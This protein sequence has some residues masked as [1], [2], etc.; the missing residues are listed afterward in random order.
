MFGPPWGAPA[1]GA[2]TA[3]P[4]T[5]QEKVFN[6]WQEIKGMS[7]ADPVFCLE[8]AVRDAH[9]K[10][11]V[12]RLTNSGLE[13]LEYASAGHAVAERLTEFGI[14]DEVSREYCPPSSRLDT[15]AS[16]LGE[17]TILARWRYTWDDTEFLIYKAKCRVDGCLTSLFLIL[18]P[19]PS[20]PA[21]M[22]ELV[23]EGHHRK[24]DAL[25]LAVGDYSRELHD[26]VHVFD[27][28]RWT[29]SK[30]LWRSVQSASWDDVILD[31]VMKSSIIAD[32]EGFFGSRAMYARLKVPWKR[33]V[34]L[35][36]VPGNG[37]TM[38]IK[39]L[40]NSLARRTEMP[41]QAL[42][43]KSLDSRRGAKSSIKQIFDMARLVAP[44]LLIFEDLDSLVTDE[45]KAYF[46][47]EVDGLEANDG[48]LMIG[49]TNHI[50]RLDPAITKRPSR[51]DRKYHYGLPAYAQR[52]E[53]ARYWR[54]NFEGSEDVDFPEEACDIIA[55]I[56][57]GYSFAYMKELFISSLMDLARGGT[58]EDTEDTEEAAAAKTAEKPHAVPAAEQGVSVGEGGGVLK[59]VVTTTNK[60][61]PEITVPEFLRD[62]KFLRIV[63]KQAKLLLSE[64]DNASAQ[65][66]QKVVVGESRGKRL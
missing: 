28:M 60:R 33:G 34:I 66:V 50:D 62:N 17:E 24:T 26:E 53:Y 1:W 5:S 65:T 30:S 57:E 23:V 18:T 8:Q 63:R 32:V 55:Q 49:S 45:S 2:P 47:N 27:S 54:K 38:T 51:F 15:K 48:I 9:P 40:I 10:H 58:G 31:P 37:K 4:P 59:D 35:H 42:Y 43:V 46:L 14:L 12:T 61:M 64:I 22:S 3:P 56:T 7:I 36:G 16:T 6:T 52:A 44:C 13:L 41:V 19:M 20:N 25:I 29:K 11:H 21:L 39:A